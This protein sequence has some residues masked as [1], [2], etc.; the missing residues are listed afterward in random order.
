MED[1]D[2]QSKAQ[3]V[4]IPQGALEEAKKIWMQVR[5]GDPCG[6]EVAI[7]ASALLKFR[8]QRVRKK[9]PFEMLVALMQKNHEVT[10]ATGDGPSVE[11]YLDTEYDDYPAD[12]DEAVDRLHD[13]WDNV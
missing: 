1:F 5:P 4:E 9:I 13:E 2:K 7:I 10:L 12:V 6:V 11:L 8:N 3:G